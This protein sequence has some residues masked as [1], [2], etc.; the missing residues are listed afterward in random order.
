MQFKEIGDSNLSLWLFFVLA[1][2]LTASTYAL[3][4]SIRS[5]RLILL[6]STLSQQ[7]RDK[8]E[9][10]RDRPITTTAFLKWLWSYIKYP[11]FYL[12]WIL[13]TIVPLIP[14]WRS[15]LAQTIKGVITAVIIFTSFFSFVA[16]DLQYERAPVVV[17]LAKLVVKLFRAPRRSTGAFSEF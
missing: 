7:I 16:F 11:A 12:L 3:R 17:S 9:I 15:G 10:E 5:H 8:A 13:L 2:I 1:F 6:R 14:I 4:L